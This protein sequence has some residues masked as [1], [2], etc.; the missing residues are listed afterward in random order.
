MVAHAHIMRVRAARAGPKG[1]FGGLFWGLSGSV[2]VVLGSFWVVLG[3]LVRSKTLIIIQS[4]K[5]ALLLVLS[6]Q[7]RSS[8]RGIGFFRH[9]GQCYF[10]RAA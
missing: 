3:P 10:L 4:T 5:K 2:W 6:A 8:A 9:L 7:Q 1:L